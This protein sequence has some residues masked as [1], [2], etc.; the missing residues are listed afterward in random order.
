M[1]LDFAPESLGKG[2]SELGHGALI[3]VIPVI[4]AL[5]RL[6]G[7]L[8]EG[9]HGE[10]VGARAELQGLLWTLGLA[11]GVS[12]GAFCSL[13]PWEQPWERPCQ[14]C[15]ESPFPIPSMWQRGL[16]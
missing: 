13:K 1:N 15:Q 2:S 14:R 5:L 16:C 7:W 6:A 12:E 9:S 10:G 4:P 8:P 11:Q 3:P